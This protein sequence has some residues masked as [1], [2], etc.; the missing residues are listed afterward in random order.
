MANERKLSD[1]PIEE[2]GKK[3]QWA[4][5]WIQVGPVMVP[6]HGGMP[7]KEAACQI[8]LDIQKYSELLRSHE[9]LMEA[10]RAIYESGSIQ[11]VE[12]I[13]QAALAEAEKLQ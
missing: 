13:A 3:R 2:L 7:E 4:D 9:R 12:Q 11:R 8:A 1:W 10:L 5:G 6:W